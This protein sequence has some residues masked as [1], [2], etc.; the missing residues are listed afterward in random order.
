M[1]KRVQRGERKTDGEVEGSRGRGCEGR[2]GLYVKGGEG[3]PAV[4]WLVPRMKYRLAVSGLL[5]HSY[6]DL[7]LRVFLPRTP[8]SSSASAPS[9]TLSPAGFSVM[10]LRGEKFF[11]ARHC[12]TFD[13]VGISFFFSF[14]FP[15][16]FSSHLNLFFLRSFSSSTFFRVFHTSFL[17]SAYLFLTFSPLLSFFLASVIFIL[18]T[19]SSLR[20]SLLFSFLSLILIIF[21]YFCY[22]YI[23]YK[24]VFLSSRNFLA[25]IFSI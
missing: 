12:Q 22:L 21:L 8:S 17:N 9:Y 15:T 14:F 24:F 6:L 4:I 2:R 20:I 1:L 25:H 3:V 23:Y 16:S 10:S 11:R 5:L 19:T 13:C 18:P 7:F